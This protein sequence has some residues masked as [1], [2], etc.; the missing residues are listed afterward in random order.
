MEVSQ[1]LAIQSTVTQLLV[2]RVC[3]A[4]EILHRPLP[5]AVGKYKREVHGQHN[6]NQAGQV[7]VC[8]AHSYGWN[9]LFIANPQICKARSWNTEASKLQGRVTCGADFPVRYFASPRVLAQ[10]EP[11]SVPRVGRAARGKP[12]GCLPA[13]SHQ[14]ALLAE[15]VGK[16][17]EQT[18]FL[19]ICISNP[20]AG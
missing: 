16:K 20:G 1:K 4:E 3:W 8:M 7:V 10:A 9:L 5:R 14:K 17:R 6:K 19:T 11:A 2:R 13:G 15:G 12:S 18:E